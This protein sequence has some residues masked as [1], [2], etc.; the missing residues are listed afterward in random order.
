M[1]HGSSYLLY[2]HF[3]AIFSSQITIE[4]GDTTG[5]HRSRSCFAIDT[6]IEHTNS[7]DISRLSFLDYYYQS[8][9]NQKK[10]LQALGLIF[11]DKFECNQSARPSQD[12]A[13]DKAFSLAGYKMIFILAPFMH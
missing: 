4:V 7:V 11:A 3:A 2:P 8:T 9:L 5:N 10:D 13:F 1:M 12:E 6:K